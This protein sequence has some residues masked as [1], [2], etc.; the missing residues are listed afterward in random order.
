[1]RGPH[2]SRSSCVIL[3]RA[4]IRLSALR[5]RQLPYRMCIF[6]L[7]APLT[8]PPLL[9]KGLPLAGMPGWS[10]HRFSSPE[11]LSANFPGA[12]RKDDFWVYPPVLSYLSGEPQG[13]TTEGVV[14]VHEESSR[15]VLLTLQIFLF[16]AA[17]NVRE[18][19]PGSRSKY[20]LRRRLLKP[21]SWKVAALGQF[22]TS[23]AYANDGLGALPAEE[24]ARLLRATTDLLLA[25]SDNLQAVLLKDLFPGGSEVPELLC[26]T[27]YYS[28]PV[29]PVMELTIDGAWGSFDDYLSSLSSKYRVRYRRAAA[30]FSGLT[31]RKISRQEVSSLQS[32]I[33]RLYR[34][35]SGNADYN[36]ARL[37]PGYFS[38]LGQFYAGSQKRCELT[39]YFDG[40]R[41]IG[42][43]SVIF[44][45]SVCHAHYLGMEDAYKFSHHLYHNM[46][47]DLLEVGLIAGCD[48]IDFGRTALEIK[49]SLGAVPT[50]Y[51]CLVKAA[52]SWV[53]KLIPRFTPAVY[54]RRP[55][56][57]RQPF[58]A[59][60][61]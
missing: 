44:N 7:K 9:P 28:L 61:T 13:F 31:K 54:V 5:A 32:E 17:G 50:D 34:A 23:G 29:D 39:G 19:A 58:R 12:A 55:W 11:Q 18:Q 59:N 49:S 21:F 40:G 47:Y 46:L 22:L 2:P 51:A 56:Q 60:N 36:A 26:D 1:M 6:A 27:G 33:F 3:F 38:W 37:T 25:A 48:R 53:N 4:R 16:S 30:K 43:T 45:G 41:L 8:S 10:F 20:D 24:Q 57:A 15:K 35:T 14:L 42:F 52:N